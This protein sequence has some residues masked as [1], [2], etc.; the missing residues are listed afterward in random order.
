[1][2]EQSIQIAEKGSR[3][4]KFSLYDIENGICTCGRT[5][6]KPG[7]HPRIKG[8]QELTESTRDDF[9]KGE[10]YGLLTGR[11]VGY[12]VLDVDCKNG[13]DGMAE[14]EKLGTIPNTRVVRTPTGGF[15]IYF[16]QPD[17]PIFKSQSELAPGLDIQGD[18]CY[19]VGP[20][21][22]GA[23][24]GLYETVVDEPI[25]NA[26]GWLLTWLRQYA[27]KR[28]SAPSVASSV[29]PITDEHS[30]Y[31]YRLKKARKYL[32]EQPAC[33][34]GQ[35]GQKQLWTVALYLTRSLELSVD[36]AATLFNEFYNSTC[37]P[38]WSE[39]EL[40]HALHNAQQ[41][42][43]IEPGVAPEGWFLKP[44]GHVEPIKFRERRK[45]DHAHK[46]AFSSGESPINDKPSKMN[47]GNLLFYLMNHEVWA[48]VWQQDLFRDEIRAVNPPM[49][50]D[51]E[52]YGLSEGDIALVKQWFLHHGFLVSFDDV[53]E[54]IMLAARELRYN[55]VRDYL[56]SLPEVDVSI[57]DDAAER[58]FGITSPAL[59]E[60]FKRTL[61]GA[62]KR[63][64]DPG[65]RMD[66][67]LVLVGP[68]GWYKS[69]F[70]EVMFGEFFRSQMPE[71]TG[72]DASH[73]LVGH[74]GIELSE[75]SR[76][77]GATSETIKDYLSR[78]VDTYR[79]YGTKQKI[80]RP[81]QCIFIGTTNEQ[82]FL[83]DPTGHR[84]YIVIPL[85]HKVDFSA[86]SRDELWSAAYQ[87]AKRG[88]KHWI[89][90]EPEY[91]E[92]MQ[93][94]YKQF[95]QHDPWRPD[96]IKFLSTKESTTVDEVLRSMVPDK[97]DRDTRALM[98]VGNE[99]RKI[100][101]PCVLRHEHGSKS[102]SKYYVVPEHIKSQLRA[103]K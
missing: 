58:I 31:P 45:V 18:G 89:D 11:K 54:C 49:W 101:G 50:L 29:N 15:H 81:R 103:V 76:L 37:E 93:E 97:K 19:V 20:G 55:P 57:L 13:K 27:A 91:N 77:Q 1:M 78:R 67:M 30:E 90:D 21:S 28:I 3:D 7:K 42:G 75:L 74:W 62:V 66:T 6:C 60:G 100:C 86:F 10:P 46:Y 4:I 43:N 38:P 99:L 94:I 14:L 56:D 92:E 51:A 88:A 47:V 82:D 95:E 69:S 17:F 65:C 79:E 80:K 23:V 48:G 41:K 61:I 2:L 44:A 59:N 25:V 34:S 22:P 24:G 64:I 8:W 70:A 12:F 83:R 39:Q 85:Q 5:G 96:I 16:L 40:L 53:A 102:I 68:Q 73:A 71:L 26:P 33:V 84:R 32:A 35:G 63:I 9:Q 87:L 36:T 72:R 52:Q 98:R